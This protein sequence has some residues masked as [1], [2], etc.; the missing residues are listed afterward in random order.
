MPDIRRPASSGALVLNATYEPLGVVS[1]RR[2]VLLV[3]AAKAVC[4]V[5]GDGILHSAR[6][7]MPV[8]SVVR[9]TRFVRVPYR[10]QVG[11]TRRAVFTRDGGRCAYCRGVAETIDHVIPR[12]RGG[13]HAWENVV[14]AC[15]RCNHRKGDRTPSELGWRLHTVP[16]APRG[17]AWRVLGHRI[18]DPRWAEYLSYG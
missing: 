5:D 2:A 8:P 18:P 10:S 12:S 13:R 4:V 3:L 14:A 15:A 17:P 1:V 7:A 16:R 11:L 6:Y 9:L